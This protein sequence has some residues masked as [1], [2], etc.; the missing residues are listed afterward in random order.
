VCSSDLQAELQKRFA[1]L[2][3]QAALD[4]VQSFLTG[5]PVANGQ[6]LFTHQREAVQLLIER[7]R[8]I[9]AHDLGLGKTRSALMAAKGY[10]LPVIVICPAS[11]K[12]NWLREAEA[13]QVLIKVYSWAKLP[14]PREDDDYILIADEAQYAQTLRT[15]RTQGF[16]RLAEHAR[17]VYALT[18]TPMKNGPINL[19]PLLLA[20]I[21]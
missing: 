9:L 12:I 14:Q 20:S 13:V 7:K 19:Y 18:G 11:L 17:A 1:E 3:C 4:A 8:V 5:K 16:L 2:E 21:P 10:E 6:V 15:K